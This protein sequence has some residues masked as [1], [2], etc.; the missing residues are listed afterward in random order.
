MNF[1]M[2]LIN[3]LIEKKPR[4][5]DIAQTVAEPFPSMQRFV[6]TA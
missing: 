5:I 2:K 3:Y 1:K 6:H 4:K